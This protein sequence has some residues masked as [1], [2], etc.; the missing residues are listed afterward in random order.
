LT[1][2]FNPGSVIVLAGAADAP[3]SHT[4][5]ARALREALT[6]QRFTGQLQ[7]FD[8]HTSGTLADLAQIRAD[9]AIIAQPPKDLPAALEVAGRMHCKAALVLS[10]GVDAQLA[11]QRGKIARREGMRLLGPNSLGLQR[12]SLQLN[13]RA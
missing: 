12:P 7:F 5:Q 8:I 2:L 10:S 3:E 4:P 11:D 13:A 1:P 9:L 6:A